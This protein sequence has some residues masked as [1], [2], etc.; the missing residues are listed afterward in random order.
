MGCRILVVEDDSVTKALYTQYL[1]QKGHEVVNADSGEDGVKMFASG[2][3]DCLLVDYWLPGMDGIEFVRKIRQQDDRVGV[4]IVTMDQQKVDDLCDGLSVYSV[5]QKPVELSKM[6]EK[7]CEACE[8]AH[9]SP[10]AEAQ[11]IKGMSEETKK[12]KDITKDLMNE[13]GFHQVS[14]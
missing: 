1:K 7:V 10:E 13:T 8:L 6:T 4:V 12:M 3:Y 14:Q 5:M 2:I 9:M 11:F